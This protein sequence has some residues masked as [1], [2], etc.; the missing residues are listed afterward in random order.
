MEEKLIMKQ[1]LLIFIILGSILLTTIYTTCAV[2]VPWFSTPEAQEQEF[3]RD[4]EKHR[5]AEEIRKAP[6]NTVHELRLIREEM[7]QLRHE[8]A[9]LRKV[10]EIVV[11]HNS[12]TKKEM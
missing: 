7:S 1:R 5:V 9:E 3:E 8:I 2:E 4:W 11:K 6:A 10:L 12:N